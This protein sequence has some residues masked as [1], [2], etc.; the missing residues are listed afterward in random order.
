[1][2]KNQ[3]QHLKT[4]QSFHDS[5][6]P[7]IVLF[8]GYGAD[9][10][11]LSSLAE[12]V[13]LKTPCNWLFPNGPVEVPIGPGW[14]GSAWWNL[15]IEKIQR[16]AQ[17]GMARSMSDE[18][19][20]ELPL[21]REKVLKMISDLKVPWNKIIL[22]GFSQGGMLAADIA[23][24][25][26]EKPAGLVILSSGLINKKIWSEQIQKRPDNSKLGFYQSHGQQDSVIAL[27]NAQQ[28][29]EFF[30][31]TCGMIGNFRQFQGGHEIPPLVIRE[32]GEFISSAV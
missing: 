23:L 11:D 25:A 22:G 1:M 29:N 3:S 31:S 5:E 26:P 24:H 28:M 15:D 27:K 6:S 16:E 13:P 19:P 7:W 30:R 20:A 14:T 17:M 10:H 2:G 8:H 9:A 21:V 12:V 32:M 4:V 18:S